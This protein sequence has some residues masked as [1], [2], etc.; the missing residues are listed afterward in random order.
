MAESR[1]ITYLDEFG[2]S[3]LKHV[4][5]DESCR[6]LAYD[7]F[8]CIPLIGEARFSRRYRDVPLHI[9]KGMT[10]IT[11]CLRGNI[12]Y[13]CRGREYS[14]LPGD[15]FAVGPGIPHRPTSFPK[16][17]HRYRILFRP[18][19][20]GERLLGFSWDDTQF[21]SQ[22]LETIG[23]GHFYDA[24]G[25]VRCGF[26]RTLRLLRQPV[27]ADDTE[28]RE[29]AFRLKV[30]IADLLLAILRSAQG[31][32]RVPPAV[33]VKRISEEMRDSPESEYALDVLA[34]R[35]GMSVSTFMNHFK[36]ITGLPPHTFLTECRIERAKEYIRKNMPVETAAH[37]VGYASPKQFATVFLR[38]TG[39]PPSKW[40]ASSLAD[41]GR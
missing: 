18:P 23:V 2:A 7:G 28:K 3:P 24:T 38:I 5:E 9:H 40:K 41:P 1:Y 27:P 11:L 6:F 21:L 35:L 4:S 29:M 39:M 14:F 16:G 19:K 15:I 31:S 37:R 8:S 17:F 26:Q 10:E 34:E 22:R 36:H 12:Q 25:D 32:V 20:R 13:E 33:A 30:Y